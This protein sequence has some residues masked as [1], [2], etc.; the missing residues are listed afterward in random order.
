MSERSFYSTMGLEFHMAL[1]NA[2]FI[3]CFLGKSEIQPICGILTFTHQLNTKK[4]NSYISRKTTRGDSTKK[5]R[6]W[7]ASDCDL[8]GLK[9]LWYHGLLVKF[10]MRITS[11]V[12]WVVQ[13]KE[14]EEKN[15]LS[16]YRVIQNFCALYT[17]TSTQST[18]KTMIFS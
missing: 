4:E 5:C 14:G 17:E 10:F 7:L 9:I 1:S 16:I 6:K 8:F 3:C 13:M 15:I 12:F 2:H 11:P 18:T